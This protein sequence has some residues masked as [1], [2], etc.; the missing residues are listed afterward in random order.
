MKPALTNS[1]CRLSLM[2]RLFGLALAGLLL[3]GCVGGLLALEQPVYTLEGE[4][5]GIEFRRYDSYLVAETWV[6]DTADYNV[7]ANEGFNRLFRYISGG[8]QPADKIAMTAPVQQS[9]R[10]G[11]WLVSFM[12]PSRYSLADAPQPAD[13]RVRLREVRG[14]LVAVLRFSGRWT[15]DNIASHR[16]ELLRRL[17]ALG[18]A[19]NGTP[20]SAAYNPP[21]LPPFLRRNEILVPVDRFP[22][23]Q[24]GLAAAR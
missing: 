24:V 22:P 21:F 5:D 14:D 16:A 7:A 19:V 2:L 13:P 20:S 10:E 12:V 3:N 23:A 9:A 6:Q 18:I 4:R 1:P 15:A 11:G 8:N 17:E